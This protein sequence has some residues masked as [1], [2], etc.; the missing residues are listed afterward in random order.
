MINDNRPLSLL[1]VEDHLDIAENIGDYLTAQGHLVDFAMDGI[2]GMHLAL[3]VEFDVIILDLMLPGMDGLTLCKKLRQEAGKQTPVLM[4]TARDTLADKLEGFNT[5]ADDYLVKPF[6]LEE[7]MARV[8]A[9][10]KRTLNTREQLLKVADLEMDPGTMCVNRQGK[11]VELNRTCLQI[12]KILME[13]HPNVVKRQQ[14]E[15]ALWGD[16]PPGSDSLRSHFYLL[17]SKI[18]KPFS[19]SILQTVHGIGYRLVEETED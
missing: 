15:T 5:G 3:T 19:T 8:Y 2:T 10:A 18:D 6:A 11:P 16:Q 12:L 14:L 1:V 17:R 9:L 7:L 4:L 13:A